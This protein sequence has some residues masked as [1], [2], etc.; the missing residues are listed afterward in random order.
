MRP[1]TGLLR[2]PAPNPLGNSAI[3]AISA[4]NVVPAFFSV[5]L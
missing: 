3:S 5:T 4:L 2:R 1:T